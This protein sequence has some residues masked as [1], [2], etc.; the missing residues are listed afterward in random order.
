M[1]VERAKTNSHY[2]GRASRRNNY[3][4]TYGIKSF[5]SSI[6]LYS[7]STF[8]YFETP[9]RILE[10][11]DHGSYDKPEFEYTNDVLRLT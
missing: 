3:Y 1:L 9:R 6:L 8:V 10:F 5:L 2:Q 7:S 11:N 4:K